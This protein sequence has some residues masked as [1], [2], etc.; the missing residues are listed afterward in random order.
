MYVLNHFVSGQFQL[1]GLTIDMPQ[2]GAA[3]Q[4]NGPDLTSHVN[5][6]QTTFKQT[7]NFVAVDFYEKG[8]LLQTVAQVNGVKWNNKAA[9]QPTTKG[10]G[11]GTGS[12]SSSDSG[13]GSGSTSNL[14]S[15]SGNRAASL[16]RFSK[17][18]LGAVVVAGGVGMMA[19]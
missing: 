8:N 12:G 18:T 6:C 16:K 10:T 9:T 14:G 17:K 1:G 3:N 15:G 19:L 2:P 7:P 4:T 13:S 5:A 11:A